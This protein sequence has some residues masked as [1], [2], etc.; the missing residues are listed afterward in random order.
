MANNN[1]TYNQYSPYIPHLDT[2]SSVNITSPELSQGDLAAEYDL[3]GNP[4]ISF[5]QSTNNDKF[6]QQQ[7]TNYTFEILNPQL[8][9]MNQHSQQ[10][11][12]THQQP[13]ITAS[14]ITPFI[15]YATPTPVATS[16]LQPTSIV[17]LA[18][19]TNSSQSNNSPT[20]PNFT[21]YHQGSIPGVMISNNI[22][23]SGGSGVDSLEPISSSRQ[24]SVDSLDFSHSYA[25]YG[26]EFDAAMDPDFRV[27]LAAEEDKRRRNTAASARFRVK[28]KMR[29]QTLEKTAKDMTSKAEALEGK[30]KELELEIKWLRSLI[31]EKDAR[32]LDIERPEKQS[33]K[34]EDKC[35]DEEK[36]DDEVIEDNQPQETSSNNQLSQK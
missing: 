26:N 15:A 27:K 33:N 5:N 3:W 16:P 7:M 18:S 22:H 4:G 9:A 23:L 17:T 12:T 11:P 35:D 13:P 1:I 8:A 28:K 32:L 34:D 6:K 25:L 2:M 29:E 21:I 14:T 20:D 10:P 24:S 31:V 19:S 36:C 30:V